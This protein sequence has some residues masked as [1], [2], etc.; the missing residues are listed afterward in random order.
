MATEAV[1][2]EGRGSWRMTGPRG[3]PG[4]LRVRLGPRYE[5]GIRSCLRIAR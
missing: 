2:T 3:P 1:G 5:G 4:V